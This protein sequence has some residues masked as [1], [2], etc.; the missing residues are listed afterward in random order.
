[1]CTC[2]CV[3]VGRGITGELSAYR[4]QKEASDRHAQEKLTNTRPPCSRAPNQQN[5]SIVL[6]WTCFNLLCFG[7][8]FF[9]L[10][11]FCLLD[12]RFCDFFRLLCWGHCLFVCL[13][14]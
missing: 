4:S 6:L 7:D 3:Y 12:F 5:N 1:M 14:D 10:L 11:V 9:V 2:V 8:F 13:F